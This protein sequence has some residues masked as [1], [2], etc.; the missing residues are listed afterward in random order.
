MP[1]DCRS[2]SLK[3]TVLLLV[4]DTPFFLAHRLTVALAAARAGY[5]VH[6]ATPPEGQTSKI[7]DAGLAW[8]PVRLH[9][10]RLNVFLELRAF[11]DILRV[12]RAIRPDLVYQVPAK[13]VLYGTMIARATR[14]P[15]VVNVVAGLGYLHGDD[16]PRLLSFAARTAYRFGLRHPCMRVIFENGD[17]QSAFVERGWITAQQA[18]L[19]RGAGVDMQQFVPRPPTARTSTTVVMASRLLYSKGVAEFVEAARRLKRDAP[20]VR[21]ILV[22][23]PDPA[24]PR[25]VPLLQIQHWAGEGAIDFWGRREDMPAVL[26]DADI[27]C[28]PTYYPE[29]VP[30]VLIEAA[31]CGR[32]AITTDTPGCR[33]IVLNGVTGLLI[34]PRNVDE[35]VRAILRLAADPSLRA[36]FGQAAREHAVRHFSLET[37]LGSTLEVFDELFQ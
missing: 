15:R 37:V 9:R 30:R 26:A 17:D 5:D 3:R 12:F 14:V 1:S 25:S 29:G 13:P 35:L 33:D 4:T 11:G 36:T 19:I 6:V 32:P 24:N 10:S 27:V 20:A 21:M 8:H 22:G 34:A 18:V 2:G 7:V 23:E 16:A 28:L 31:A